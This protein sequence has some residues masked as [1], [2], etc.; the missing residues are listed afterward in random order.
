MKTALGGRL[1][2]RAMVHVAG[3]AIP[4][5]WPMRTFIHHNPLYG[6]EHLSFKEAVEEGR[7]LFHG[8]GYLPR[9]VYQRY[10]A[11]GKVSTVLLSEQIAKFLD[12]RPQIPGLDS[13]GLLLSLATQIGEPI[14]THVAP[15]SGEDIQAM[16]AGRPL[17]PLGGDGAWLKSRLKPE[18]QASRS[19]YTIVDELYGT[20][21]G[22]SLNELLIKSCLDFFD[23]GQSVWQMPGRDKGLFSAWSALAQRNLRLFIRGLHIKDILGADDTPEGIISHVMN[24][25]GVPEEAW[26]D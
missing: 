8:N 16:L 3:E 19:V 7:R 15:A 14:S 4:Y 24:E 5:F 23:E 25:L 22:N 13:H 21:I 20:E 1:K 26:L 11:D 10:L 9:A 12:G 6:L 2:I 17:A 18:M